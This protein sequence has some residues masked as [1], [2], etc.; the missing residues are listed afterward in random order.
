MVDS[1]ETDAALAANQAFYQAF[2]TLDIDEMRA[3]WD[4]QAEVTCV[5]PGWGMLRGWDDVMAS[6][7]RIMDNASMMQFMIT[8]AE[9]RVEGDWAWV[10][11]TENLTSV[12]NAQANSSRV[13]T[14][15]IL[16]RRD[17]KWRMVHHHGSPMM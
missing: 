15:N 2:E 7:D 3:A 11:C 12:L 17:G 10:T 16:R 1:S 13:Q 4:D 8:D 5:H 14:T 9:A 6:W